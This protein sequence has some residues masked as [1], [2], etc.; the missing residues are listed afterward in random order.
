MAQSR[1]PRSLRLSDH[2]GH[3]ANGW[4]G[5]PRHRILSL[6]AQEQGPGAPCPL[7]GPARGPV[8]KDSNLVWELVAEAARGW[9]AAKGHSA[10]VTATSVRWPL[11]PHLPKIN[12]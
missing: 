12:K 1:R 11:P 8:Q 4:W 5:Q 9:G 6:W 7:A 10:A 2:R 3:T